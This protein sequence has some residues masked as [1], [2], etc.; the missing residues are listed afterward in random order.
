M[1]Y[2]LGLLPFV[3]VTGY[4]IYYNKKANVYDK[5]I[6]YYIK[7]VSEIIFTSSILLFTVLEP[8]LSSPIHFFILIVAFLASASGIGLYYSL[9]SNEWDTALEPIKNTILLLLRTIV[10]LYLFLT[11]FRY[12]A[13]YLQ[14]P[15]SLL[16]TVIIFTLSLIVKEKVE[17]MWDRFRRSKLGGSEMIYMWVVAGVIVL[18]LVFLNLSLPSSLDDAFNLTNHDDYAEYKMVS[19]ILSNDVLVEETNDMENDSAVFT[20]D[21]YETDEYI[22]YNFDTYFLAVDKATGKIVERVNYTYSVNNLYKSIYHDNSTVHFMKINNT[23]ILTNNYG[24]FEITADNKLDYYYSGDSSFGQIYIDNDKSY[25]LVQTTEQYTVIDE[26][27]NEIVMPDS[28]A[29]NTLGY[30]EERLFVI[31]DSLFQCY[32]G[33]VRPYLDTTISIDE[34]SEIKTMYDRSNNIIYVVSDTDSRITKE[35]T[36]YKKN[37]VVDKV[38]VRYFSNMFL[39]DNQIYIEQEEEYITIFDL[40]FNPTSFLR[41]PQN[42]GF[43]NSFYTE[44]SELSTEIGIYNNNILLYSSTNQGYY[45]TYADLDLDLAIY[46]HYSF[47]TLLLI[48][49]FIFVPV[50]DY[51]NNLTTIDFDTMIR[52]KKK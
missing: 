31:N 33:I 28:T 51:N 42:K 9:D 21:N 15:L 38:S 32:E 52:R 46:T 2:F 19:P 34:V 1:Y 12:Q 18:L 48:V 11:I 22:Y 36:A 39:I 24:I 5:T 43:L 40:D 6:K 35:I 41:V 4:I 45:L 47:N 50:S 26:L 20:F 10:P 44:D 17:D 14:V 16:L 25:L 37:G 23:I 49:F 7:C 3:F 8:F 27:G 29:Q 30:G 13:W